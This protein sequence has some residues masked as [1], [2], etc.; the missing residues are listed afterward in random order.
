MSKHHFRSQ[1]ADFTAE[2][3]LGGEW[4]PFGDASARGSPSLRL[5]RDKPPIRSPKLAPPLPTGPRG[6]YRLQPPLDL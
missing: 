1:H 4:M 2:I 5:R 3:I 6:G